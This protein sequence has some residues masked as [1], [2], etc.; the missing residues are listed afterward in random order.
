ML[1]ILVAVV[2]A[3]P[4]PIALEV[5]VPLCDSALIACGGGKAG[6]PESLAGNLYWGA[7]YGAERYL[8]R[9]PGFKVLGS[10]DWPDAAKPYLLREVKLSRAPADASERPVAVT[11]R[12]YSGR[13]IDRALAD[14]LA[15]AG[16]ATAADLVVWAGHNRLMDVE[17]P[18]VV[19]APRARPVAI[20]ACSSAQYFS[21]L[22]E[23]IGSRPIALARTFMAPE[24]Y[25]L[26]ALAVAVA[27]G[28][29][30]DRAAG[31]ARLVTAH[32]RFQ[33]ISLRAAGSVFARL[34]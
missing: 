7:M 5:Y 18:E 6:D 26:E 21:P 34:E 28:G 10:V 1:S 22:L 9:A 15:A 16:G 19:F 11:L 4:Q 30:N 12:A 14:L 2:V 33:R 23:K 29:L 8:S 24:A 3:A 17:A 20:L 13:H 27:R 31:R 32:A 25:L